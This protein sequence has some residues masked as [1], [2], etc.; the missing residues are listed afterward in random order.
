VVEAGSSTKFL[1]NFVNPTLWTL[2]GSH[3]ELGGAS[4]RMNNIQI[5]VEVRLGFRSGNYFGLGGN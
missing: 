3:K 4:K 2:L 1:T 5:L